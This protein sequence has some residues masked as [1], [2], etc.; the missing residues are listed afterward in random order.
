MTHHQDALIPWKLMYVFFNRDKRRFVGIGQTWERFPQELRPHV[1]DVGLFVE[2]YAFVQLRG[3][4]HVDE[5]GTT[6]DVI[7]KHPR[8]VPDI[9]YRGVVAETDPDSLLRGLIG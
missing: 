6:L 4:E 2:Q 8:R 9:A 5:Q 7:L 1:Q 3:R